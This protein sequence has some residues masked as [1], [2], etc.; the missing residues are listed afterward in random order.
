[1][2]TNFDNDRQW[3]NTFIPPSHETAAVIVDCLL[4]FTPEWTREVNTM[5]Y[6]TPDI[7]CTDRRYE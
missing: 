6:T 7:H 5:L 4:Y 1:M 2:L 3:F